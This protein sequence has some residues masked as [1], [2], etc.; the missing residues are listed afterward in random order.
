MKISDKARLTDVSRRRALQMIGVAGAGA[1]LAACSKSKK[2]TKKG[3]G[4]TGGGSSAP[5]SSGASSAGPKPT[6]GTNK[7]TAVFTGG[8]PYDAPPKGNFNTIP[9]V[10]E[11][12]PAGIGLYYDYVVLPGAMYN[13][14]KQTFTYFIADESSKL[15][16]DGKTFTYKV[17]PGIKWSDGT[18]ITA[19]DVYST[20]AARYPLNASAF[21]YVDSVTMTDK[22]TVTFHIGTPAPI[23]QYYILRGQIV[24]DSVYG[25]FA[26]QAEPLMKAKAPQTDARMVKLNKALSNFKPKTTVASGPYNIDTSTLSSTQLTM[27]ANQH[28]MLAGTVKF[29]S[30]VVVQGET[31]TVT[32][33]LL[34]K[35]MDY[36]THGF[37]IATE[38]VLANAGFR[39]IR[40]PVYSGPA[41]YFN[42]AKFPEF[43]DK[44]ARQALSMAFD[45]DQNGI[46][47]LGDSGK[48]VKL[49][50]GI[51][52]HAVPT[53][54]SAADQKKLT[55][56]TF[57]KSKAESLL[58]EAGWKK[59]GSTWKT[60]KGKTAAYDLIYP[61]DYADWSPAAKNLAD[62]LGTFGIKITLRGEQSTQEGLDVDHSNFQLAI[63]GWGSS[64]NPF[65]ADAF[66]ASLFTHNTPVL[67]PAYK[68]MDFPM[69]QDT[70]VVG[71]VDLE[72]VVVNSGLGA[73]NDALK[74]AT[75]TAALAFN[76]L[77]PVIPLFERFGN[78]PCLTSAVSGWPDDSDPIIQNSPY[79]DNFCAMLTF[80]GT[81][82]P[83]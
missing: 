77:L 22:E 53:W 27:K 62:Q 43:S 48:G 24:P 4:S 14:K 81:L 6:G 79:A 74:K 32:P 49:F 23:A 37:P 63:Q 59:S 51:P 31:A 41:L 72:K 30:V 39:I 67:K 52:D 61:S 45:H 80:A 3:G 25:T 19:Q 10:L 46:V 9:G 8:Y 2:A 76:E 56:W 26:K 70:K 12:I 16:A 69:V 54:L 40:P 15:S 21:L 11:S 17:R 5:A 65:P 36:A 33:V 34:Q 66:R 50:A 20:W 58:K 7:S 78:N 38:K 44:R 42:F 71:K 28:S 73:N 60:P 47:A 1:A 29:G 83:A 18:P 35:R 57:D 55:Q 75:T 82:K 13:W 68:G 64:S